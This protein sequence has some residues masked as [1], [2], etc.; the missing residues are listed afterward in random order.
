[1]GFGSPNQFIPNILNTKSS[2]VEKITVKELLDDLKK[3]DPEDFGDS[4]ETESEAWSMSSGLSDKINLGHDSFIPKG[5]LYELVD[6]YSEKGTGKDEE[7]LY[8]VFL[9]KSDSKYFLFWV[10]NRGFIGPITL[11]MCDHLEEVMPKKIERTI[12]EK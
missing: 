6:A 7:T 11:T 8:G 1:M 9:R 2:I 4:C 12:W 3:A 5:K 10:H